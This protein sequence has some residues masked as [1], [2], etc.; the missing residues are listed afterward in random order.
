MFSSTIY[1]YFSHFLQNESHIIFSMLFYLYAL[2]YLFSP[3]KSMQIQIK[4]SVPQD[5]LEQFFMRS[6]AP[7]VTI[8][9]IFLEA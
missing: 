5:C 6:I 8:Y 2:L 7:N 3:I 9:R 4:E 1:P